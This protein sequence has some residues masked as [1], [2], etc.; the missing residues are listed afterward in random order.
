VNEPF[1]LKVRFEGA[2]NAKVIDLPAMALPNQLEQYDTK[3]ESKFFKNGRSY[4]EFEVLL[5]P[6]Q[7]G[8]FKIPALSVSMFDPQTSKYYT[9]KTQPITM[10]AVSN[11]NAPVGSSQRLADGGKAA[12]TTATVAENK[13]PDVIMAWQPSSS[14]GMMTRPWMWFVIFAGILIGLGVKAQR[15]FGWGQRRRTLKELI[16]KRYKSLDQA[17]VAGDF[18]KVGAEMTNI[19][20]IVLGNLAGE[21]SGE[22][23][24]SQKLRTCWK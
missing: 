1:S 23:G 5:I 24:A 9:K 20:Y 3:S 2:G 6:R 7:E 18:R 21:S 4:K 14:G 19:F 17:V 10:K 15:E 16:Q 22:G 11:P 8:E 12:A 13:L